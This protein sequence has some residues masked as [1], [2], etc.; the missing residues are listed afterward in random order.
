MCIF[1]FSNIIYWADYP[2]KDVVEYQ[3][4][5]LFSLLI[6]F[7]I[8]PCTIRDII[9]PNKDQ[10]YTA[11]IGIVLNTGPS[12]KLWKSVDYKYE[13]VPGLSILVI[14]LYLCLFSL[15]VAII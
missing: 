8:I 4:T 2:F 9:L 15:N 13:F 12:G 11:F 7:L 6:Y 5:I 14:D 3:F 1:R 10:T